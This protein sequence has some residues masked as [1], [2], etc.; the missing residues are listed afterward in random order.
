ML[1][2]FDAVQMIALQ[3]TKSS[4]YF[5][6]ANQQANELA[7]LLSLYQNDNLNELLL[8][9]NEHNQEVLPQ[10]KGLLTGRDPNYV[11]TIS[12]GG[13]P[14]KDCRTQQLKPNGGCLVYTLST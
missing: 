8:L 11:L 5:A 6:V 14:M 1:L 12:W 2:G 10:G 7:E 9:W 3:E 4:Y 13:Y